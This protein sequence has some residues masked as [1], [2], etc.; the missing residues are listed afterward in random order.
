MKKFKPGPFKRKKKKMA[1]F[2]DF[3][4]LYGGK[5][6]NKITVPSPSDTIYSHCFFFEWTVFGLVAPC[7][8]AIVILY[9]V[10]VYN[11]NSSIWINIVLFSRFDNFE[12]FR[13]ISSVTRS[14][15]SWLLLPWLL[16]CWCWFGPNRSRSWWWVRYHNVLEKITNVNFWSQGIKKKILTLLVLILDFVL[17][18]MF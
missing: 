15:S 3:N 7:E 5:R 8:T 18:E 2:S 16:S 1:F 14:R 12:I 11:G 17:D 13:E 4:Q 10:S 9:R 6:I